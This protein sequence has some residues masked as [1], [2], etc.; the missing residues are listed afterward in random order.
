MLAQLFAVMAPVLFGASLGFFWIKLGYSF[1]TSFVSRLTLNIGT[2]CLILAKLPAS[3][4]TLENFNAI[5]VAMILIM[6]LMA[7]AGYGLCRWRKLDWQVYLPAMLFPN[8]GNMGLPI[9]HYAFGN[10]GF[11][12]AIAIMVIVSLVQFTQGSMTSRRPL[13]SLVKTPT[14]YAIAIA[15]VMMAFHWQLPEW[16]FNT[17]DLISGFTIP[18]MLI[19]LGVSLASIQ[20]RNLIIG[21][22]FGVF[23]TLLAVAICLLVSMLLHL[24]AYKTGQ[25]LLQVSMPVAVYNYLFAQRAG[26]SPETVAS[27]VFCSTLLSLIYLP[28]ILRVLFVYTPPLL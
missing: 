10:R 5:L 15:L 25:I 12:I 4:V 26:R 7:V 6:L 8:T 23:R 11:G 22:G 28:I 17:V 18:L 27:L 3:G 21:M 2:P 13:L 20:P 16:M 19:T 14:L 9:S 1:P 24:D